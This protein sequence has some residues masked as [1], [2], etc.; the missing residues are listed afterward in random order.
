VEGAVVVSERD[1]GL[2]RA[3]WRALNRDGTF[4]IA[5]RDGGR[6]RWTDLQHSLLSTTWPR[7]IFFVAVAYAL[8]NT[9]FAWAYVLCGP[10][11]IRG[12]PGHR[13]M[14]EDAFFFSVQTFS[15]VGYG[16]LVPGSF[17]ANV[18]VTVEEF[19]QIIFVALVMGLC[20]GR[21]AR[22]TA[23]VVFSKL[24]IVAPHDGV[25]SFVLRMA[26]ARSNQIVE[27][28][29]R[30]TLL[31]TER[32]KEGQEYSDFHDLRVERENTAFFALSWTVV[33]P[34]DEKSPLF[35]A[36]RESLEAEEA[37][38]F[39]TVTGTDDTLSQTVHART[40]YVPAEIVWGGAFRDI[41][42]HGEDG[43]YHMDISRIDDIDPG[44]A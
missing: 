28:R 36:T 2:A 6:I 43:L 12:V 24:A 23:R 19:A 7:F 26:N 34:I 30:V 11:A 35:G 38:I 5:R 37:E 4:N 10:D 17:A 25:P 3:P 15:T 13:V 29:I 9:A 33:H 14:F 20:W 31:R 16:G 1:R 39:V 41:I 42:T 40:S 44:A 8:V 21:F 18:V 22:P 27:A 32:T